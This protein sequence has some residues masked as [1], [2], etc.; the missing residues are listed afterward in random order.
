MQT[1]DLSNGTKIGPI[2]HVDRAASA[3]IDLPVTIEVC[4]KSLTLVRPK[5][6]FGRYRP[7]YLST[8]VRATVVLQME[9]ALEIEQR[10]KKSDKTKL[11]R[12]LTWQMLVSTKS[13]AR[14][15]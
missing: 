4:V 7:P 1:C 14:Q 3:L 8:Q 13:T 6:S 2:F 9:I 5:F 11:Q 15:R 12:Q 10:H